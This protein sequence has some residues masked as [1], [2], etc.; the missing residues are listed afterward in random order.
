MIP[1]CFAYDKL[2]YARYMSTFY[3]QVT[4]LP[5]KIPR[6][7]MKHSKQANCRCRCRTTTPLGAFLWTRLLQHLE[8]FVGCKF[9]LATPR[10]ESVSS[11]DTRDSS[12]KFKYA[13]VAN[14]VTSGEGIAFTHILFICLGNHLHKNNNENRQTGWVR[15]LHK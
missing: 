15:T 7:Y 5:E 4:N 12:F 10:D 3:V 14:Y 6:V 2:N 11:H 1:W 8:A 9:T 13:T